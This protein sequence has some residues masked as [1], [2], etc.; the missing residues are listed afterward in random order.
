MGDQVVMTNSLSWQTRSISLAAEAAKDQFVI[1]LMEWTSETVPGPY[2]QYHLERIA[3]ALPGCPFP[4]IIQPCPE[5][6]INFARRSAVV[7]FL[8]NKGISDAEQRIRVAYPQAEGLFGIE[9]PRIFFSTF[10]GRGGGMGGGLGGGGLG[11]GLGVGG[12]GGGMGLGGGV[13]GGR[14]Y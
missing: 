4:V 10:S 13:M 5:D 9:A 14:G 2:G 12:F 7:T 1:Y 3:E 8:L 11:G 6:R